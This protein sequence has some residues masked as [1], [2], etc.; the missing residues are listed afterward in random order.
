MT[1][2]RNSIGCCQIW[3][4]GH[5]FYFLAF[6]LSLLRC[7]TAL[8]RKLMNWFRKPFGGPKILSAP[9]AHF[10]CFTHSFLFR[11]KRIL[12]FLGS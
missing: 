7:L 11:L 1:Y 3:H 2:R 8:L 4:F 10:M 9:E 6:S 12:S 5:A